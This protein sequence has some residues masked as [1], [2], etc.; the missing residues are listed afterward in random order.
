L[1]GGL[2]IDILEGGAGSDEFHFDNPAGYGDVVTDFVSGT[3]T[4]T[5]NGSIAGLSHSGVLTGTGIFL[6]GAALPPT[7]FGVSTE[8]IYYD[9]ANGGLWLD[10]NGGLSDDAVLI[11][12]FQG[13]PTILESDI[14]IV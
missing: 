9:T 4:I 1:D 2:G 13:T 11:A 8:V 14:S 10:T 12:G 3:D 5:I 7:D 6:S